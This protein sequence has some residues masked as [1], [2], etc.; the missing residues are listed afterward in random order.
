M[1]KVISYTKRSKIA[2]RFKSL[3][4]KHINSA[5]GYGIYDVPRMTGISLIESH[6]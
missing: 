4:A 1:M 5:V 6:R 3:T 2:F